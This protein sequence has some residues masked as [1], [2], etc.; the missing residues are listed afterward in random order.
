MSAEQACTD[1]GTPLMVE[2]TE[3]KCEFC[4]DIAVSIMAE[5]AKLLAD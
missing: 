5:T 2:D 3:S 4:D 1:C